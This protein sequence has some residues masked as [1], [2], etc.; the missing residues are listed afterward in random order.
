MSTSTPDPL[1]PLVEQWLQSA[2]P[3]SLLEQLCAAHP[4]H[5]DAL[6]SRLAAMAQ[7]VTPDSTST[8]APAGESGDPGEPKQI[9]PYRLLDTLGEGGM[10]TVY[11]AEQQE[12][13][14]RRVALKLIKLGMDT[15]AVV[16]RFEQERQALA[17]MDHDGI[18]KVYDVGTSD[19]GQPY[20]VMELVK[21]MP[22][23]LFCERHRL[24]LQDRLELMQ[25][26]CAAVQHAHQKGV[27]HRDLKPGNVLVG[28]VD[29]RRQVK[30]I[31][32]GLAK[33]MGQKLIQESLFTELGVVMGTPEFMAPEQ[34]DPSNLDVD[35][36]AD[37]YSL[38]VVLYQLLVGELPFSGED[39][40]EAGILGMQRLL[41]EVD[42]PR[43]STRLSTV[44]EQSSRIA[45]QLR[46]SP[47][48]LKK[49]IKGELDWVVVKAL[50]K[51]RSRRYESANALAA[52][53]QRY[54][55][56]EP[57]EAGPPSA[58]YRLQKLVRRN[59]GKVAAAALVLSALLLG[60]VGTYVQWHRAV[61]LA[62][63]K[64]QLAK[65][66]EQIAASETAAKEA[67]VAALEKRDAALM[68]EKER[69]AELEAVA[70]FQQ[71]QFAKI[72]ADL[73]GLRLGDALR[74]LVAKRCEARGLDAAATEAAMAAH[75]DRMR[76]VDFTGLALGSLDQNFFEPGLRVLDEKFAD[77]PLLQA[78]LRQTIATT[79]RDLGRLELALEP[80]QQAVEV[81]RRVLGVNHP[82]TLASISNLGNL[83]AARGELSA[84]ESLCREAL[85][86]RRRVLGDE[87]VLTLVSM[88]NLGVILR[89]QG[90][91]SEAEPLFRETLD[92]RRRVL[93]DEHP[94]T[95]TSFINMGVLLQD[96]GKLAE[97]EPLLRHPLQ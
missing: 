67:A 19:R 1:Q 10:G 38:G 95:L 11:L 52:D 31:D 56:H 2:D 54:L 79:L 89:D 4:E 66:N 21:G 23:H 64:T 65:K 92:L 84:S 12:P 96:Q 32:F 22:I 69:S 90:K 5:A 68:A 83:L 41:R 13:V 28:E 30:V 50:E 72:D 77:Q 14:Q 16:Q 3:D 8:A 76:G 62:E 37:V 58:A 94:D 20:F 42:P 93:G 39:L 81:H 17:V 70:Q 85:E 48:A 78:R 35:T 53:L 40:R 18:A 24:C 29:G 57:L 74:D 88:S 7:T 86:V 60:G 51:D 59:R 71:D 15:K 87:H 91:L 46:I 6:R 45:A 49:A 44:A 34:A 75:D 63:Q 97:A 55:D 43:P 82:R 36:R 61:E 25:Q 27:I 73:M 80:Q 9:G 26:V 47:G 33:A